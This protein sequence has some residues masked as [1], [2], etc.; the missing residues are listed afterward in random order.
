M[1]VAKEV[2]VIATS[3]NCNNENPQVVLAWPTCSK[4]E[5]DIQKK[6]IEEYSQLFKEKN[7][8]PLLC[9]ATDGDSTRRQI[10]N[11]LMNHTLS[12]DSN[13]YPVIS[14]LKLIDLCVGANEETVDFDAKHLAKRFRNTVIAPQF[15]IDGTVLTKKDIPGILKLANNNS[16]SFEQLVNPKD[17][18]NVSLAT[19]LLIT[20]S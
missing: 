6:L 5:V 9:W 1:H 8:A 13:I 20:F 3:N 18:Q 16:H 14:S 15:H 11:S 4:S 10:F 17:K 12:V 2:M 19:D 7:G